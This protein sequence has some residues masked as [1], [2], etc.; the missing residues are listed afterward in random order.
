MVHMP[1]HIYIRVGRYADAAEANVRA[2]AADEDYLA[3]CQRQGLYPVSYYPH[4]LHFL[5][6]AATLEGRSAAA[7]EAARQ[8]AAKVPHHHAGALAWT[9]DFP[10]TPMLAYV[11]FGKWQEMLIEPAPPAHEPYANGIWHYGR[12][13][14]FIARGQVARAESELDKLTA[15][16]GHEAFKTRLKDLPLL[17]NLQIASR[18]VRGELAARARRFDEA[19]AVLGEAITI[20]D[21]FP[22]SEP[23]IWHQPTRQVLGAVLLQAGRSVEAEV[24]YRADLKRFPENGW[25]LFGLWQSLE[26]QGRAGDAQLARARFDKAWVRADLTLTSSRILE[27]QERAMVTSISLE[28]GVTLQ[29]VERGRPSGVPVIFLH[30]VSDSWR[31]FEPMFEHLPMNI[32]AL[33]IS[34]RGHGQSGKPAHG[35]TYTEM[36]EDLRAFMDRLGLRAAVIVGHS[37]G[38]MVAQRFA[39]DYPG[40]VAGLVL[41]GSFKTLYRHPLIHELWDSTLSSLRDPVDP[42]FVREFQVST[43]ARPVPP[44][45]V[46]EVV[47]E[48]LN[49]PARV[50]RATFRGFLDAPDFSSQLTRVTAPA[51]IAWGDKDT[52]ALEHDQQSLAAVLPR[53]RRLTYH[54]AGHAFHWEE[55]ARFA[56]D[57]VAFVYER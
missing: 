27:P 29:Y 16:L 9:A 36:S 47:L 54:G 23:P 32:R 3:Q 20:E 15:I 10:V 7:I 35:Y 30:G 37:M 40:R 8:V 44:E 46:D 45:F 39:V 5:W 55:P 57:L 2:V 17:P 41:M 11:R 49:L 31:S 52:Y 56:A 22:Y 18:V 14:A 42:A 53:A 1:A 12:A 28:T 21:S 4:N 25:S 26:A 50:W 38:S 13:L 24:A 43:L 19:T 34:Q 6:A 33:A 51:L 48:S